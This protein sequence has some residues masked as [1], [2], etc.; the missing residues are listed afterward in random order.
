MKLFLFF[1]LALFSCSIEKIY[2]ASAART[3][4]PYEQI[5]FAELM[6]KYMDKNA[7]G[8]E[9]IEGIYSVSG[10]V[11]KKNKGLFSSEEK[12]RTVFQ[13]DHY[14]R[15]AVIRD[16]ARNNR[17][18]IEVPIDKNYLPSYSIRG[19]FTTLSEGNVLVLK[20]FEPKGHDLIYS[21]VFDKE[22]DILEGIRTETK[23]GVTYTYKLT[24]VKLYPKP[25]IAQK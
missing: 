12:E 22:K 14:A 25:P 4:H 16:N 18:F 15:V 11:L 24:F 13:K 6:K 7:S 1:S 19:E 5:N 17:E 23:G 10:V 21:F 3:Q 8:Q 2:Q 9:N 20:H